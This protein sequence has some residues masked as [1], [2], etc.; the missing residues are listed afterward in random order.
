MRFITTSFL[1]RS[2]WPAV[3]KS[4]HIC[5]SGCWYD[6]YG[7]LYDTTYQRLGNHSASLDFWLDAMQN[8]SPSLT[9]FVTCPHAP[10]LSKD[11][12]I[13]PILVVQ[14]WRHRC[15]YS[16]FYHLDKVRIL[17]D[18]LFTAIYYSPISSAISAS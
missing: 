2:R 4:L 12:H 7:H 18:H 15:P 5:K 17:L 14:H 9:L 11:D 10:T 6:T 8:E 13:W 16:P 1:D 3:S